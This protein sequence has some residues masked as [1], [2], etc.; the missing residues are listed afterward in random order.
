MTK[1]D[2]TVLNIYKAKP[3]NESTDAYVLHNYNNNL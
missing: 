3:T 1:M 2:T